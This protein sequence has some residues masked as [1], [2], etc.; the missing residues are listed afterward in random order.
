[1][2]K[3]NHKPFLEE[4]ES[5]ANPVLKSI[6]SKKLNNKI[7]YGM[8]TIAIEKYFMALLAGKSIMP[9]S[10]TLID[11]FYEF[12][13]E[14]NYEEDLKSEFEFIESFEELCSFEPSKEKAISDND[15]DKMIETLS[16]IKNYTEKIFEESSI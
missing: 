11:L 15:M 16:K 1:M 4:A 10:H 14:Y 3:I 2:N 6:K 7:N 13:K 8:L 9:S 5:F 12:K